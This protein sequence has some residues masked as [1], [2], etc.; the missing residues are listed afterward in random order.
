MGHGYLEQSPISLGFLFTYEPLELH[1]FS[2]QIVLEVRFQCM[3]LFLLR[4]RATL[5]IT[6]RFPK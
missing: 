1:V 3:S 6:F 5:L 2:Q 4:L